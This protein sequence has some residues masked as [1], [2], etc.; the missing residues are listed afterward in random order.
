MDY[1]YWLR[2]GKHYRLWFLDEYLACFRVHPAS[3]GSSSAKSQFD[4]ELEVAKQ[5]V[6]SQMLL[7][8]HAMHNALSISVYNYVFHVRK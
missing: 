5:H 4:E 3:K 7:K 2:L 1:D 8:L 6:S